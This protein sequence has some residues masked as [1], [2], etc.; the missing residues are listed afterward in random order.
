MGVVLKLYKTDKRQE[1][2]PGELPFIEDMTIEVYEPSI[3]RISPDKSGWIRK[4]LW[5]LITLGNY[6]V[7]YIKKGANLVHYSYIIPRNF[8][9]PFMGKE[10]LQIG[11]C[12]TYPGYRNL[13]I[14]SRVLRLI[15]YLFGE[16]GTI[17]WIYTSQTNII[18]QKAIEKS[19]F[20]F[21]AKMEIS[22]FL[23]ILKTAEES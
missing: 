3:F 4:K 21:V 16:A 9:F 2:A 13:G 18:S 7:I 20:E 1:K 15:P 8:R 6:K 22:S 17:F 11:P 19:G 23:R 14:Y 10:D 5:F 12:F